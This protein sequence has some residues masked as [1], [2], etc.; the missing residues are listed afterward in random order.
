MQKSGVSG[1]V[2]FRPRGKWTGPFTPSDK[3]D[4]ISTLVEKDKLF[5]FVTVPT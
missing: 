2:H 1:P 4:I 3:V 5:F